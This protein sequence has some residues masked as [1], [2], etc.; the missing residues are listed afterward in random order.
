MAE[1]PKEVTITVAALEF[2]LH[3]A[4]NTYP[5]EFV[6]LLRKNKKG[7]IS[8]VLVIPQAIYGKDFSSINFY[9]VAYTSN[10][11]GSIHSHPG[12]SARPSREDLNFFRAT[13]DVHMIVC[14]P[15]TSE[16]LRAY[17][18][19]GKELGIKIARTH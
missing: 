13:G 15:F 3:A 12:R 8:E 4:R 10:H 7:A 11:C 14:V 17:D 2:I 19:D 18:R 16:A 1:E 9:N 5:D 6:G